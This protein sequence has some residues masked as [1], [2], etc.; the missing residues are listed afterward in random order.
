MIELKNITKS[1]RVKNK[2]RLILRNLS[3]IFEPKVNVGIL[4]RNGAG[5]STLLRIIGGAELPDCGQ[6]IRTSRVSWPI[7]FAGCFH[8]K[9]T[10][11][12][13]MRFTSRIYGID[14]K[15]VTDF[16]EKFTAL[17]PYMDMPVQ[18]YSSGMKAKLAFG[19]SMA[20]DFN[21][22]LIDEVTAVGDSSFQSKC[23]EVFD[24]RKA[25]SSLIVVSHNNAII[26]Q[27]CDRALV[28]DDGDLIP[29]SDL[30]K[31]FDYY[32]KMCRSPQVYHFI[33]PQSKQTLA[34]SLV[35]NTINMAG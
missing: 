25:R 20:L 5:K 30:G 33:G 23:K 18:T 6:A 16:V 2:T 14:I 3:H 1:Y 11:R 9:L 24:E 31:A 27:H 12:E 19:L 22:Y 29:F 35:P 8:G 17:G 15:A 21:F 13:N 26:K 7:G 34:G 28:L 10:G 4:G 32:D